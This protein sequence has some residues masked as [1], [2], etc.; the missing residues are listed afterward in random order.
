LSIQAARYD[1]GKKKKKEYE[2]E[3]MEWMNPNKT[4]TGYLG[5]CCGTETE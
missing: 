1:F 4:K 2:Q 3:E 5:Y